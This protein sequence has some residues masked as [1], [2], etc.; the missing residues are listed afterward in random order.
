MSIQQA[1][2]LLSLEN[3]KKNRNHLKR[4][5][6]SSSLF[7]LINLPLKKKGAEKLCNI[8]MKLN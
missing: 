8:Y 5:Y 3:S 1:L 7:R 2:I 4:L 6:S